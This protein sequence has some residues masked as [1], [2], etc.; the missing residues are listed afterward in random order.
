MRQGGWRGVW[1]GG[2]YLVTIRCY[3]TKAVRNGQ[4][5]S[6]ENNRMDD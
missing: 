5:N 6:V 2:R 1:D 3:G 4:R